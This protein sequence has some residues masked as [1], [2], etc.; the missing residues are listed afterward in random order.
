MCSGCL[1]K[2]MWQ[3]LRTISSYKVYTYANIQTD[4]NVSK[5]D[6]LITAINRVYHFKHIYY[7]FLKLKGFNYNLIMKSYSITK[8]FFSSESSNEE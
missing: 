6:E 5:H 3:I 4:N 7:T 1:I 2:E 8:C